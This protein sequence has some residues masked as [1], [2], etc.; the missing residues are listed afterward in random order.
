MF[1]KD[2]DKANILLDERFYFYPLLPFISENQEANWKLKY[3]KISA[4]EVLFNNTNNNEELVIVLS[5]S[6]VITIDLKTT[7]IKT[8]DLI[9]IKKNTTHSVENVDPKELLYCVRIAV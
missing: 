4:E 5:G 3:I 9:H 7:R 6:G 2:L 8:G 1:I